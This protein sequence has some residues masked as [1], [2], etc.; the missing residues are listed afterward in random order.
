MSLVENLEV[1]VNAP[2][3]EHTRLIAEAVS[4][5]LEEQ[6]VV[7]DVDIPAALNVLANQHGL[8]FENIGRAFNNPFLYEPSD[9]YRGD[10][11][12][13]IAAIINRRHPD[14]E[15][16]IAF[17]NAP[18]GKS[19]YYKDV[20]KMRNYFLRMIKKKPSYIIEF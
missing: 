13:L 8:E 17:V 18:R 9:F 1:L 10:Y 3:P 14:E 11:K 19:V 6:P 12:K 15:V 20:K 2:E 16:E 7:F 4:K 5:T